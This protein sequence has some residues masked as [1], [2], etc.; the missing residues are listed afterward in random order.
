MAKAIISA[1]FFAADTCPLWGC[2][3]R[4]FG[5]G[6]EARR[7]TKNGRQLGAGGHCLKGLSPES[8]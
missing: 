4:L 6:I 8:A 7:E 2:P 5:A 1:T 3:A